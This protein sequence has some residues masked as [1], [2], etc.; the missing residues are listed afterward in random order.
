MA[1]TLEKIIRKLHPA[2]L[3]NRIARTVI[4]GIAAL[5]LTASAAMIKY[6][7][8]LFV[9]HYDDHKVID[10]TG[11]FEHDDGDSFYCNVEELRAFEN[12]R[13]KD[14]IRKEDYGVRILGIDTPETIHPEDGIY[15]NQKYG[16]KAS[17]YAKHIFESAKKI[18]IIPV[19]RG[20]Y[21]RVLSHVFVDRELYA[22]KL[23]RAG[24]AYESIGHY[25]DEGFPGFALQITQVWNDVKKP[26]P[27]TAPYKWRDIWQHK[28]DSQYMPSG[29]LREK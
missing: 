10:C 12:D 4:A 5:S 13:G 2:N 29:E 27:F 8:N 9:K 16:P 24:L 23:I 28:E 26:L 20:K 6:S 25:G 7:D 1:K 21:G 15:V 22:P 3:N 19:K 17:T 11:H 18:E 14:D